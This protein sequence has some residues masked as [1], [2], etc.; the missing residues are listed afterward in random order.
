MTSR[1]GRGRWQRV[2]EARKQAR[3]DLGRNPI[4]GDPYGPPKARTPVKLPELPRIK[5]G[6]GVGVLT[7]GEAAT[8]LGVTQAQLEVMIDSG[9]IK[10]LPTGFT[11][12]IPT[13]EIE[14]LRGPISE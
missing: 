11:R 4:G 14:R 8:K 6:P 10:A 9:K 5:Y 13:S 12:T 1:S 2:L 7:L 3:A